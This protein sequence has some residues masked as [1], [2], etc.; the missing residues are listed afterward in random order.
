MDKMCTCMRGDCQRSTQT[1][2]AASIGQLEL[3]VIKNGGQGDLTKL[4]SANNSTSCQDGVCV[5]SWKPNR[6][7]QLVEN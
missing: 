2:I 3:S 6:D 7:R 1:N 5:V 4:D